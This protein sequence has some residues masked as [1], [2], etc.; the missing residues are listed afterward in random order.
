MTTHRQIRTPLAAVVIAAAMLGGCSKE[1]PVTRYPQF[2]SKSLETVAVAPFENRT[3]SGRAGGLVADELARTL[4]TRTPYE[5]LPPG[6]LM[7]KLSEAGH[8]WK[9]TDKPADLLEALRKVGGVDALL[10]GAVLS[11]DTDT[12][13]APESTVG[14]GLGYGSGYGYYPGG[15]ANPH[16]YGGVS[17]RY[18]IMYDRE[19]EARVS[20][21][22]SLRRVSD[23]AR[24]Y[25][26][27]TP[28]RAV[29]TSEQT[30]ET[31]RG[32]E[33][34]SLANEEAARLVGKEIAPWPVTLKVKPGKA[35]KLADAFEAGTYHYTDDFRPGDTLYAVL[36]LPPEAARN[37]FRL[38]VVRKD[39]SEELAAETVT[40]DRSADRESATFDVSAIAAQ[41]GPGKYL[42]RLYSGETFAFEQDFEIKP[43]AK[44]P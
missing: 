35:L 30:R 38:A 23:G 33:L 29:L 17:R 3:R 5:V 12:Y 31:I 15:Y 13:I 24:L 16:Y 37:R 18:P 21:Q 28:I 41:A 43:A 36:S 40:W 44:Q 25:A 27:A 8:T 34:L 9:P 11:Y 20:V 32:D 42:M 26:R 2:Y 14:V 10:T 4:S 22:V 39:S 19:D 6:T 7:E 1:L